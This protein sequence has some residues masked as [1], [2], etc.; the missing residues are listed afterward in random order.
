ML[1]L[2]AMLALADVGPRP[3]PCNSEGK[4]CTACESNTPDSDGG[5]DAAALDAGLKLS[6]CSDRSGSVLTS[7]YC[8][9]GV[10]LTHPGC[11]GCS[12]APLGALLLG[13][14]T[15]RARRSARRAGR[16]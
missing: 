10:T 2:V 15:F 7:Y 6:D 9:P 14:L 3:A 13:A 8:P 11:G 16:S 1:T 5:C 12:S 4:G